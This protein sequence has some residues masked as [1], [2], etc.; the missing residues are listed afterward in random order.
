VATKA[1]PKFE[2]RI[3]D[4][5]LLDEAGKAAKAAAEARD[6]AIRKAVAG[7]TSA[8]QVAWRCGSATRPCSRSSS[9]G[10]RPDGQREAAR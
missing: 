5:K 4:P 3:G 1:V 2:P 7:G 9:V 6:D 10:P 8:R